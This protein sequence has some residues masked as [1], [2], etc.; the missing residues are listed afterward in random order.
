VVVAIWAVGTLGAVLAA[1]PAW[2]WWDRALTAHIESRTLLGTPS[3]AT[4]VELLRESPGAARMIVTAAGAAALVALLLNPLFAGGLLGVLTSTA[5]PR[6]SA[7]VRFGAGAARDYGAMVRAALLVWPVAAVPIG[8]GALFGT[9]FLAA[10]GA[11]GWLVLAGPVLVMLGVTALASTIVDLVRIEI[12]RRGDRRALPATGRALNFLVRHLGRLVPIVVL[13]AALFLLATLGLFAIRAWLAGDTWTSIAAGLAAQQAHAFGRTWLRA[14][15]IATELALVESVAASQQ[16]AEVLVVVEREA[17]EGGLA[18]D[19][20]RG[21][22]ELAPEIAGGL[23]AEG[24][25]GRGD[26]DAGEAGPPDLPVLAGDRRGDEPPP[27]A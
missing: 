5:D 8:V 11:P 24:D 2:V 7:A 23:P 4:L 18:G 1:A 26:G 13:F 21:G 6:P 16:R 20:R 27:L 9:A 17:G 10:A 12:S 22:E 3:V 25:G 19:E 15:L 14:A